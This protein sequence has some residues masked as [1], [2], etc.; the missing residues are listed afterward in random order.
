[1]AKKNLTLTLDLKMTIWGEIIDRNEFLQR[2]MEALRGECSSDPDWDP[3]YEWSTRFAEESNRL[4]MDTY[5]FEPPSPFA[6][7]ETTPNQPRIIFH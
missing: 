2:K 6:V 1:M 7:F 4:L 3:L 5:G